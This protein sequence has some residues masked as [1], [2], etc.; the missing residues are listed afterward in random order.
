M[1]YQFKQKGKTSVEIGLLFNIESLDH[2]EPICKDW[3][4]R[5]QLKDNNDSWGYLRMCVKSEMVI[6]VNGKLSDVS[7]K[8]WDLIDGQYQKRSRVKQINETNQ[9]N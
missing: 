1:Q 6:Y 5:M 3:L 9:N 8:G 7:P 4:Q 2:V